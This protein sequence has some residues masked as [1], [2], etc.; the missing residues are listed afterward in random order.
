MIAALLV[1]LALGGP[2][3]DGLSPVSRDLYERG[4]A[5]EASGALTRAAAAYRM[6]WNQEPGWT[7]ALIDEAR[8]LAAAER[9]EDALRALDRAPHVA[10]VME[11]RGH[12]LQEMGR[13]PE[14][15]ETF[16]R[17]P[18]EWPGRHLLVAQALMHEDPVGAEES[19]RRYLDDTEALDDEAVA[20]LAP[21]L[22]RSLAA[23]GEDERAGELAEVVLQ[24]VSA[25]DALDVLRDVL[26]EREVVKQAERLARAAALPLSPAGV[27][28][29]RE[30]RAQM[31]A[32]ELPEA[33]AAL[34]ALTEVEPRSVAA[35]STRSLADERAGEIVAAVVA[36]RH[37][38]WLD[39]LDADVAARVG[40]LLASHYAGRMDVAAARAY[41][42]AVQ[43]RGTD[44][45]LWWRKAELEGRVGWRSNS[46][47]SYQ[48]VVALAPGTELAQ[49]AVVRIEQLQR[50][51]PP[52]VQAIDGEGFRPP[53]VPESAWRSLHVAWAWQRR[54]D[55]EPDA[56]DRAQA[57]IQRTLAL[58]PDWTRA[59]NLDAA[60]RLDLGDD[61]GALDRYRRSLA[62]DP[63]QGPVWLV[64]GALLSQQGDH[65][66]AQRAEERAA[67]LGEPE[68]LLASAED[69]IEGWRLWAARD[70]LQ[71][72][73]ER[74]IL[75]PERVAELE[76][77]LRAR[78][79]AVVAAGALGLAGG[80][81]IPWTLW[82]RR[83]AGVGLDAVLARDARS[84]P[85]VARILAAMRHEVIKHHTTVLDAV[86]D[87]LEVGDPGPA[88]WAEE[89]LYGKEGAVPAFYHYLEELRGLAERQGLQLN[90]RHADPDLSP[91]VVAMDG[92]RAIEGCLA[93]QEPDHLRALARAL[94]G[95]GYRALGRKVRA[96]CQQQVDTAFVDEAWALACRELGDATPFERG[97]DE[98]DGPLVVRMFRQDLLDVLVNVLRNAVQANDATGGGRVGVFVA[99]EDDWVTGLER[100]VI[101][102]RDDSTLRIDTDQLRGRFLGRG[103][104]LAVDRVTQAGG[105]MHVEEASGW[106]KAVTVRLPRLEVD[107]DDGGDDGP[108]WHQGPTMNDGERGGARG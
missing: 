70:Q 46:V 8:V 3:L 28:T 98:A 31:F 40:E 44:V 14:A 36:A 72:Y 108:T 104:G 92:L 82:R 41:G 63:N 48:R 58:A 26:R 4:Q 74:S 81:G 68:A 9:P 76:R 15:A 65:E 90:L 61:V 5:D 30:A 97:V 85:E 32:G 59:V 105:S 66:E 52:E 88:A 21:V 57:E 95:K 100:V 6:V 23:L 10:D 67:V 17:L 27:A 75:A 94:N 86:A 25:G 20:E 18:P 84:F 83:R 35:W 53:S 106:A 101:E 62:L 107:G 19:L 55:G 56:L 96:L 16:R 73:R 47:V 64:L 2:S 24:R 11:A 71:R 54:A 34:A 51:V 7:R 99:V 29:L 60:I 89:R 69:H 93:K 80:V 22:V 91:V 45:D 39:P 49:D 13:G 43:R 79:V 1:A 50:P 12:L 77:D 87:A 102:V 78:L 42:R 33:R 38:E 37:A 103:L